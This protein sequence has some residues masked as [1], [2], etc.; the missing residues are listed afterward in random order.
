MFFDSHKMFNQMVELHM[1]LKGILIKDWIIWKAISIK[2]A[3]SGIFLG[4]CSLVCIDYRVPISASAN[5]NKLVGNNV[6]NNS[7]YWKVN[8]H[9]IGDWLMQLRTAWRSNEGRDSLEW[10]LESILLAWAALSTGSSAS[11]GLWVLSLGNS[12]R[13]LA[14]LKFC[15]KRR[16]ARWSK[17]TYWRS[18]IYIWMN[19]TSSTP[20]MIQYF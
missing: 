14:G 19:D 3:L 12:Q 5:I 7:P 16:I 18:C 8:K 6:C 4:I 10:Q 13:P 17:N 15:T 9:L 20:H 11:L 2:F 1:N